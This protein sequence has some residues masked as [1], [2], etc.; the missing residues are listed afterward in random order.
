MTS[1]AAALLTL[2]YYMTKQL[3]QLQHSSFWD[4]EH[5][6]YWDFGNGQISGI[7]LSYIARACTKNSES[8]V[9]VDRIKLFLHFRGADKYSI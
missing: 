5:E 1:T 9:L 8:S 7:P 6:Q 4:Y 2:T 3:L